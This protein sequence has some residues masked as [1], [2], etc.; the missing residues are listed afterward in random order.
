MSQTRDPRGGIIGSSSVVIFVLTAF[1]AFVR[2]P[3]SLPHAPPRPH[4]SRRP[5]TAGLFAACVS[6]AAAAADTI[7]TAL[8]GISDY[9]ALLL[10]LLQYCVE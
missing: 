9:Y 8:F 6:V 5:L 4:R 2:G 10:Q 7:T 3:L 1:G